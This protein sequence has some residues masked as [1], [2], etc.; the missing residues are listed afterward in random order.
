MH[1]FEDSGDR[2]QVGAPVARCCRVL[3]VD[4]HRSFAEALAIAIDVEDDLTC[5]AMA[6]TAAAGLVAAEQVHPDRIVV[7]LQLP[8]LP[9]AELVPRLRRILPGVP[10]VALTAYADA[11][12][13]AAAARAGV[14]AFLRKECSLREIVTTLRE[15]GDGPMAI[16]PV[17]LGAMMRTPPQPQQPAAPSVAG[18]HL[19]PREAEVLR[20]LDL[21][22]DARAIAR[23]LAIS[24][25]TTR[26]YVKT[27]LAK[28]DAHTQL[29]AVARARRLG[30][31][32]G[33][34]EVIELPELL[35]ASTYAG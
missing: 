1:G 34:T 7:D 12:S 30:L 32:T 17:T 28:L 23:R 9:G 14:S 16:D 33:T 10:I 4:D 18:V 15:V 21:G 5:A 31:L 13:V 22:C 19:T 20:L 8:D 25:H 11:A 26:G 2:Q 6:G 27:L 3:I 35:A 24:I 29:E